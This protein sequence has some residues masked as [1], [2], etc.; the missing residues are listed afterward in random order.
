MFQSEIPVSENGF[1]NKAC[2]HVGE[3]TEINAI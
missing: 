2:N 1:V 3:C